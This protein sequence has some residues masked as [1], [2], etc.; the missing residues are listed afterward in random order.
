[1]KHSITK[2]V[3]RKFGKINNNVITIEESIK[4]TNTVSSSSSSDE[5]LQDIFLK[6][7]IDSEIVTFDKASEQNDLNLD[8]QQETPEL[9]RYDY[10]ANVNESIISSG[11]DYLIGLRAHLGYWENKDIIFN[12]LTLICET[13]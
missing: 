12:S 11:I 2:K 13:E 9:K 7:Q 6:V 5:E 10:C 8:N 3:F 1:M 4:V